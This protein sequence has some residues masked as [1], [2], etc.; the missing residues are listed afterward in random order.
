MV[1][2]VR[3]QVDAALSGPFSVEFRGPTMAMK[4]GDRLEP[5]WVILA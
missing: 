3:C 2:G 1:V 5:V 4:F